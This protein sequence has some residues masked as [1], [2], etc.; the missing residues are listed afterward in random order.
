MISLMMVAVGGMRGGLDG[1]VDRGKRRVGW[2]YLSWCSA[3]TCEQAGESVGD[4]RRKCLDI[5]FMPGMDGATT[6]PAALHGLPLFGSGLE[7]S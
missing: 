3:T 2:A 7:K 4:E 6:A 1:E 5:S